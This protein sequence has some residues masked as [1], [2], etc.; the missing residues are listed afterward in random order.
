IAPR[1]GLPEPRDAAD[2]QPARVR[3]QVRKSEPLQNT[4]PE[5]LQ[6]YVCALA[7][8]PELRG[9]VGTL[10]IQDDGSLAAIQ[11]REHLRRDLAQVIA[12]IRILHFYD[13]SAQIGQHERG[14]R[15]REEPGQVQYP[16]PVE[17]LTQSPS[18]A[19]WRGP[20]R[21]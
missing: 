12:R 18:A 9:T 1:T 4:G 17:R 16:N 6:Q 14:V 11:R 3:Q 8:T 10:Q 19:S 5:A 15:P 13:V 21:P 7:Q 20:C 2:H